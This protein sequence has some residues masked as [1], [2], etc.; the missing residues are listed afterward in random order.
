MRSTLF[1]PV[2]L[3]LLFLSLCFLPASAPAVDFGVRAG[4]Y[5]EEMDP[6]AGVELLVQLGSTPWFFNPNLEAI[7][8]DER[9]RFSL[10]F[11]F[12]YDFVENEDYYIWAGGGPAIIYTDSDDDRDSETD[13]GANFLAGIG[14][15]LPDITPYAQLK[16]VLSDESEIAAAVGVR[17]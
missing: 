17:F 14:W 13:G 3:P 7:F 10:N 12:H 5:L 6:Y 2:T 1:R 8:P 15:R 9:D 11:D 16:V 4:T